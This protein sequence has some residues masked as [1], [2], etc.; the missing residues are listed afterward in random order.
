[1]DSY[2]YFKINGTI[3]Y[4]LTF[5]RFTDDYVNL[6]SQFFDYNKAKINILEQIFI[7]VI[8]PVGQILRRKYTG[9]KAKHVLKIAIV[10]LPSKNIL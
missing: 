10:K 7:Y 2:S 5:I 1:M 6:S 8:N 9:L 4:H 3:L